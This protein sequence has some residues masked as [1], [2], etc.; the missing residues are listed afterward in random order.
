MAFTAL[1]GDSPLW[2]LRAR[3]SLEGMLVSSTMEEIMQS[4]HLQLCQAATQLTDHVV[5]LAEI[6]ASLA[7][8]RFDPIRIFAL[9]ILLIS[10]DEIDVV[11]NE[12]LGY[13]WRAVTE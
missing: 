6:I 4:C 1:L 10:V 11:Y 12:A 7:C 3:N 8:L 9:V 2:S 5:Q 13:F